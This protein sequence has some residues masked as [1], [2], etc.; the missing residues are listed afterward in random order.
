M[1]QTRIRTT[2]DFRVRGG[3]QVLA[4]KNPESSMISTGIGGLDSVDVLPARGGLGWVEGVVVVCGGGGGGNQVW[5]NLILTVK[6]SAG[7]YMNP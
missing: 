3:T 1:V 7:D 5:N 2:Q 6:A 4:G